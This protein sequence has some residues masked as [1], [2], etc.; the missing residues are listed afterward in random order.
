MSPNENER[1]TPIYQLKVTLEGSKPPIWRR[2]QVA[3][4]TTLGE[5]HDI[6]QVAM[7]WTDSHLHQFI[8]GGTYYGLPDP[9]WDDLHEMRDERQF[10]LDEIAAK[11]GTKF[12]YEYDF[13]DSWLHEVLVEK[14]MSPAPE[15]EY[16]LCVKGRRACPPED[17]GGIWGYE[18]FLEAIR[19][20]KHPEHE[21]YLEW[22]GGPFDPEEFDLDETNEFLHDWL[23]TG[24]LPG[25]MWGEAEEEEEEGVALDTSIGK[26]VFYPDE[27][28]FAQFY[29]F[30]PEQEQVLIE[31]AEKLQAGEQVDETMLESL[32]AAAMLM[33]AAAPSGFNGHLLLKQNTV[34]E[35][36]VE[37]MVDGTS[38]LLAQLPIGPGGGTLT[39][40]WVEEIAIYEFEPGL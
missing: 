29:F 19:D 34:G 13:G 36:E 14:I 23:A 1:A 25:E 30:R 9:D 15:E 24:N 39:V 10:R 33:L 40:Y 2:L 37:T 32:E 20:P 21:E 16:P 11:E 31:L 18:E 17:V 35:D 4:D 22:I 38:E 8:V 7:G 12:R 28:P 3:E 6:I 27:P 26:F 5:L